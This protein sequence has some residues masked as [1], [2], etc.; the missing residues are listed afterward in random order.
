M[1]SIEYLIKRRIREAYRLNKQLITVQFANF[2]LLIFIVHKEILP[3]AEIS[4]KMVHA[5]KRCQESFD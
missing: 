2:S 5:V 1:L 4:S 3:S